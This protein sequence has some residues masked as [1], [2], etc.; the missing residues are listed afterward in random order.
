MFTTHENHY[1]FGYDGVN[2]FRFRENKDQK[3]TIE[4][5]RAN[6]ITTFKEEAINTAKQIHADADGQ[7]IYISYSGGIDSEFIV[8]AFLEANV[9]FEAITARFNHNMNEYDFNFVKKAQNEYGFKLN[10]LDVDI[11]KFLATEMMEYAIATKCCSPQFPLHMH[12]WDAFDGFVVAGHELIFGRTP[13][14]KQFYLKAQ[15]KEDS[16]HRYHIWRNRNGAPAFCFYRPELAL[17]FLLEPELL[18]LF[19]FGHVFNKTYSGTPKSRTYNRCFNLEPREASTGFETFMHLD[20]MYRPK[21]EEL[22]GVDFC[23]LPVDVMMRQLCPTY[24]IDNEII[25]RH[26]R[27]I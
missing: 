2:D 5:G 20:D 24:F 1:K 7:T 9:P 3:Y 8:R 14:S 18:K 13:P 12:L 16:V 17:T 6:S 27:G 15:E 23:P 26:W 4:F 25:P 19:T 21:L 22:Y 11:E 10:V